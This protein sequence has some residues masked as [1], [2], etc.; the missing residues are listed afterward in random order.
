MGYTTEF[1]GEFNITPPLKREHE[2]YLKAFA[3]IRHMQR[4]EKQVQQQEECHLAHA[5]C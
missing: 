5:M 3:K 4:H 1:T 2:D